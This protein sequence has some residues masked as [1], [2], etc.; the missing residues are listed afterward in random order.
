MLISRWVPSCSWFVLTRKCQD[1]VGAP[2]SPCLIVACS[3]R[4]P[5]KLLI[6]RFVNCVVLILHVHDVW[7]LHIV[8]IASCSLWLPTKLLDNKMPRLRRAPCAVW[9]GCVVF[10]TASN[11][12]TRKCRHRVVLVGP[13][14]LSTSCC[15]GWAALIVDIALFWL[16]RFIVA[17]NKN[18]FTPKCRGSRVVLNLFGSAIAESGGTGSA[19]D[20]LRAKPVLVGPGR[21]LTKMILT[22]FVEFSK[23]T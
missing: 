14:L 12:S 5:T 7:R 19:G 22:I 9:F 3:L 13:P 23:S 16:R 20:R 6:S 10:T 1:R 2:C 11:C 15:F 18:W 21:S 8:L 17:S 4:P